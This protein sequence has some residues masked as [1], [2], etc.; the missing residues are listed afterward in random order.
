MSAPTDL[1]FVDSFQHYASTA[2]MQRKW[3]QLDPG[4]ILQAGVGP[5]GTQAF[6]GSAHKTLEGWDYATLTVGVRYKTNAFGGYIVQMNNGV[7]SGIDCR[8][9]MLGDGRIRASIHGAVDDTPVAG[10]A[11][12]LNT[13]Y[14][15]EVK[16]TLSTPSAG[17][18]T[19]TWEVR[20][21]NVSLGT[22][23]ISTAYSSGLPRTF[24][25]IGIGN[26]GGGDL[27]SKCDL[28]VTDGEFLGDTSWG[29]IYPNA[30]G[31]NSAW[32]TSPTQANWINTSEHD[33]DDFTTY[34]QADIVGNRDLYNMDDL[35]GL[36]FR[37][38]GIQALNCSTKSASGVAS[39]D[40][41][42]R[43]NATNVDEAEF[44][45]SFGSWIYERK[46]YRNNPVTA[47]AFTPAEINAIQ[48][49]AVRIT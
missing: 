17:N 5:G 9:D 31:A 1:L 19:L 38:V 18:V 30:P 29:V 2:H 10:F 46:P 24:S 14:F 21:N 4:A 47:V 13:Y 45:P 42:I 43:T 7:P 8:L 37:I 12:L 22:G 32:T 3:N 20:V 41:A 35:S 6:A 40:G 11:A 39:F 44:G 25:Q 23:A 48:R 27:A 15:F 33:P 26:P 36:S 16:F 34:N 28:Q 49:G